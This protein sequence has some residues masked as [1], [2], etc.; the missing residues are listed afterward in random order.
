MI[1]T[2]VGMYIPPSSNSIFYDHLRN[3]MK[4]FDPNKELI[5]V[6]DFNINWNEKSNRKKLQEIVSH[7]DLI[8]LI[9]GPT[10]I[11][12]SSETQID[13]IF[14]NK[15]ERITKSINLLTGLSDHNLILVVRKLTN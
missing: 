4:G 6:G 3:L 5:L 13:L 7:L 12:S 9:R 8:Q 10:R 14:S 2:V 15:P 1:F 11:T